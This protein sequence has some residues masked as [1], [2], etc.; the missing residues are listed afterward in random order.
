VFTPSIFNEQPIADEIE[1]V[2]RQRD[3]HCHRHVPW[4]TAQV[5]S[6]QPAAVQRAA[7]FHG[8][9]APTAHDVDAVDRVERANQYRRGLAFSL[10]DDVHQVV[11]AVVQ[12]D[13]REA[14]RPVEWR[15]PPRRSGCRVARGIG[16]ADV[17]LDFHDGAAGRSPTVPVD[18]D[19]ADEVARDIERRAV[20]KLARQLHSDEMRTTVDKSRHEG[21]KGHEDS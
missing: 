9:G 15:I 2:L 12:I 6:V 10:S 19:F 11:D 1:S 21:T 18:E 17:G 14:G 7:P 8:A 3:A 16:L 13:V 4:S 20:V 5:M